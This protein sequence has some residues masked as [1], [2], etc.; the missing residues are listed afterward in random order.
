MYKMGSCSILKYSLEFVPCLF[1]HQS[2]RAYINGFS[3]IKSC[4]SVIDCCE[5]SNCSCTFPDLHACLCAAH[6]WRWHSFEQ[7]FAY[8][9]K[10]KRSSVQ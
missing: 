8:K 5:L 10:K 7:Y 2:F 6:D 4:I 3:S 9:K 1:Q